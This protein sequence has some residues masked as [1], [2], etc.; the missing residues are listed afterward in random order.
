[1]EVKMGCNSKDNNH[2]PEAKHEPEVRNGD[3]ISGPS[4]CCHFQSTV[5]GSINVPID[6]S[7]TNDPSQ[8]EYQSARKTRPKRSIRKPKKF[9]TEEEENPDVHKII[10]QNN[11]D[12]VT[13]EDI[14]LLQ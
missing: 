11:I 5:D 2:D 10:D 3:T 13:A 8:K 9:D 14:T 1:M 12:C 7:V 4:E 6:G